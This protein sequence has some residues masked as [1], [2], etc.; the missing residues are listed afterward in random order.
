MFLVALVLLVIAARLAVVAPRVILGPST[1]G[2]AAAIIPT[3]VANIAVLLTSQDHPTQLVSVL[4][5]FGLVWA[6]HY[7]AATLRTRRQRKPPN[8]H[9]GHDRR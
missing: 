8:N 5:S 3:A 9:D 7:W 2:F 6:L 1:K 4:T